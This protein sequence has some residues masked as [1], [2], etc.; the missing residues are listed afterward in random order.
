[1]SSDEE[2][3]QFKLGSLQQLRGSS[4]QLAD[5]AAPSAEWDHDHCEGCMAKFAQFDAPEILHSGYLTMV[6]YDDEPTLIQPAQEKG[7]NVLKKP[8]TKKW[9]CQ[10]CFDEF[11]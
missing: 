2:W 11:R 5:Y 3:K 6:E 9:V 1:M 10:Q 7:S 8:D 4:F